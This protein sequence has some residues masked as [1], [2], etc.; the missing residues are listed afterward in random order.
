MGIQDTTHKQSFKGID[1]IVAGCWHNLMQ[2]MCVGPCTFRVVGD[3]MSGE[4]PQDQWLI[5][6]TLLLVY[7]DVSFLFIQK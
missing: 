6:T 5:L 3:L 4:A 2:H 1:V 7:K